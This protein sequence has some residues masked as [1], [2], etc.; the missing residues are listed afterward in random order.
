MS[1]KLLCEYI[2]EVLNGKE[3]PACGYFV[4]GDEIFYGKWKNKKGKIVNISYDEKGL[5]AVE[6]EPIPKGRRSNVII[7]LYKIR[8]ANSIEK[9]I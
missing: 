9:E 5:P 4:I 1:N 6:I 2:Q 7:G 3:D 8:R